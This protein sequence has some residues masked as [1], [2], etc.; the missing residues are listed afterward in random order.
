[1]TATTTTDHELLALVR[2]GDAAAFE[3]VLEKYS[4]LVRRYLAGI[5]RDQHFAEDLTQEVFLRVWTHGGQW[6][7]RG[8]FKAW[9]FRV[10]TNF[11]LN[12]LRSVKRR[13]ESPL[14]LFDEMRADEQTQVPGWMIDSSTSRPDLE[15]EIAERLGL[16]RRMIDGLPEEKR[17][18]VH[19]A[20]EAEMEIHEVAERLGIPEGT[21]KSRL[22]HARQRLA[23]EWKEMQT[24]WE[25]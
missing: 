14:D 6:D 21:V 7:G 15:F 23:R 5:V 10:A 1:M 9:L 13:R 22:Y 16:L 2:D 25:E 24:E 8:P 17:D 19:L 11:A 20:L 12:F 4:S 18:V 3:A